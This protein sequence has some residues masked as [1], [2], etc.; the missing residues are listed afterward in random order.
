MYKLC[1][2]TLLC[3]RIEI[4]VDCKKRISVNLFSNISS[5]FRYT[6]F[7]A[8]QQEIVTLEDIK[9]QNIY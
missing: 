4:F 6:Q 3:H 7:Y 9:L 2:I 1:L 8:Y 5:C